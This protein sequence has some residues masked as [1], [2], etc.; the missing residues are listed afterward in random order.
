GGHRA[1]REGDLKVVWEN[2][3]TGWELYDLSRD[4]TETKNLADRQP[5]L[6]NRLARQWEI[7]ARMTDVK[8]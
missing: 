7:W 1:V 3:K 8:F 6:V 5:E 2:R 4:R